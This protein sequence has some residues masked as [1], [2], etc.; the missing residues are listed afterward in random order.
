MSNGLQRG[1]SDGFKVQLG[2]Y[3]FILLPYY[4][5]AAVAKQTTEGGLTSHVRSC[6]NINT[7]G[8]KQ[9]GAR[10]GQE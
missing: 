2:I 4:S 10:E 3:F 1:G 6:H 8:H 9:Q 7:H 5:T